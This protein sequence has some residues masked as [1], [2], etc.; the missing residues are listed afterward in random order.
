MAHSLLAQ[1]EQ[2]AEAQLRLPVH[3]VVQK[4]PIRCYKDEEYAARGI[5]LQDDVSDCDILM[6]V[7]EVLI[8]KLIP[9]KT[10]LFFSHT[11]KK[12]PYNRPLLLAVLE[13]DIRLIDYEVLTN[14]RGERLVAFGF[15]AGIVGAHNA[16][17]TWANEPD[18]FPCRVCAKATTMRKY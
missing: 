12:Q 17:W 16:I 7:K 8:D 1:A 3:I 9:H 4:S 6:G 15:Y 11:I 2:C 14:E 13:K 5:D 10:Y 18:N